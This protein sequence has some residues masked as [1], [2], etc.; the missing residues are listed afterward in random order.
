MYGPIISERVGQT[1][2]ENVL[3]PEYMN[4][5]V[6]IFF[7]W[8]FFVRKK[9]VVVENKS[10]TLFFVILQNGHGK[11]KTKK[12]SK[13]HKEE[14]DRLIETILDLLMSHV[15]LSRNNIE[16]KVLPFFPGC[17]ASTLDQALNQ[18][19]AKGWIQEVNGRFQLCDP[20]EQKLKEAILKVLSDGMYWGYMG[21]H[22][23]LVSTFPQIS[24]LEIVHCLQNMD[25]VIK[26][27]GQ[28]LWVP[29]NKNQKARHK[30]QK[31][32]KRDEEER[33]QLLSKLSQLE[34]SLSKTH[35]EPPPPKRACST[36]S[37]SSPSFHRVM[38]SEYAQRLQRLGVLLEKAYTT[39]LR[40][41]ELFHQTVRQLLPC[42][43]D[44][45]SENVLKDVE[46]WQQTK[47]QLGYYT[48]DTIDDEKPAKKAF[49]D[50][51]L[52][53][54]QLLEKIYNRAL[55]LFCHLADKEAEHGCGKAKEAKRETRPTSEKWTS[56]ARQLCGDVAEIQTG[57]PCGQEKEEKGATSSELQSE[58]DQMMDELEAEA[59]TKE[60]EEEDED[61]EE[62]EI[63][64]H[65]SENEV[66]QNNG[67]AL[68]AATASHEHESATKINV[69]DF[70]F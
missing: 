47:L 57:Y 40:Y 51:Q 56:F 14:A 10:R 69:D 52:H 32:S 30:D 12:M 45:D 16:E 29:G 4:L 66:V 64:E 43:W 15:D 42:L 19:K 41:H 26:E 28:Y 7:S 22:S 33:K 70:D 3:D 55:T 20:D 8:F 68:E 24:T 39:R 35:V 37:S 18:M 31:F 58:V 38:P 25:D 2:K 54:E 11:E 9:K 1:K 60:E 62:D 46:A 17:S 13:S 65:P 5:T 53:L 61:S 44:E 50:F 21:I 63:E 6:N 48:L 49:D 59:Q 34:E 67:H 36:S 23:K 27:D